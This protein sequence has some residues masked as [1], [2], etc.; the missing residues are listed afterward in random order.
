MP[1]KTPTPSDVR[2]PLRAIALSAAALLA[3]PAEAQTNDA[4]PFY[5]GA[6]LGVTH[7][8]NIYRLAS[9]SNSDRVTSAGLLAGI[10][11]RFGRQ[12]LTVDGSLQDNRYAET[13]S[14]NNRAYSLR[15][16]LD[17]QT[18]G[19]LSG[20][21]SA[22]NTRSLAQ[23]NL[24]N[25]AEQ[26]QEKNI[27]RNEDYYAIVRLGVGTRYS[28]EAT[29]NR[30]TRD[31]SLPVYDRFV[32]RQHT[33]G[34]GFYGTPGGNLRLGLVVRYTDGSFPHYPSYRYINVSG[35][36]IPI[37]DGYA[38]VDYKRN[39]IDFTTAW[40]TGGS[41]TLNTR[42]SSSRT[43]YEPKT[44]GLTDFHGTT[45]AIGWTWRPTGKIEL[46]AQLARDTGQETPARAADVN[47]IYT[48]W[49]L[50]GT[51]A[52]TGKVSFNASVTG[53]RS[54]RSNDSGTPLAEADDRNNSYGLG[55][56]WSY[57]RS[58]SLSCQANHANRDASVAAYNF[59]ANSYGCTGQFI[60]Y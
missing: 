33:G 12:H 7:V 31:F 48:S 23:F 39:D 22:L 29:L 38:A 4:A 36:L 18:V 3:L 16:A 14:L 54:H 60:V 17:W 24:G 42:I 58:L 28:L 11:Q 21:F 15:A 41:S 32:Y 5:A 20:T 27:E 35:V 45:G 44:A 53:F 56:R 10:D 46:G 8:S 2:P 30:R 55:M 57:S 26:S 13:S 37:L 25:G 9:G 1:T 6:S 19:H 40:N 34:L 59:S 51:Y 43:R 47:A 52:L 49:Q 50:N